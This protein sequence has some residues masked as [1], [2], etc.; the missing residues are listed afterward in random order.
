MIVSPEKTTGSP[1][2]GEQISVSF[3]QEAASR[4]AVAPTR[5]RSWLRLYSI[6]RR[7]LTGFQ[8][9][10]A[11]LAGSDGLGAQQE[12]GDQPRAGPARSNVDVVKQ[13]AGHPSLQPFIVSF[14]A[15]QSGEPQQSVVVWLVCRCLAPLALLLLLWTTLTHM[16]R[17]T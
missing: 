11:G 14:Q 16:V 4:P 6:A 2:D 1:H 13:W 17:G 15:V 9:G 10:G 3:E 7:G 8:R 12:G 5:P